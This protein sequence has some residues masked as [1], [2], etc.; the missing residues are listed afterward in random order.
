MDS[1]NMSNLDVLIPLFPHA[2]PGILEA[3]GSVGI[4]LAQLNNPI[5]LSYFIAQCAHESGGFQF[6]KELGSAKYFSKYE[7][8][9]DLGNALPG[10]G[11]RFC[12]RGIIQVTGRANYTA[13]GL[14][15]DLPIIDY[16]ELLE[17]PGP[18]VRSACWYW[19][20]KN[21][22][23]IC[24]AQNFTLLTRRINGGTNGLRSRQEWLKKIQAALK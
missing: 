18:A 13:C 3:I 4:E 20:T 21:L 2:K 14:W 12:G 17:E 15:I 1:Q 24:D 5:R 6:T 7:G 19:M 9:M 10:D 22:N 23:R 11:V 8:R 16:P